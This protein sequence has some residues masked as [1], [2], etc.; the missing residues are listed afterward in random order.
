MDDE[1]AS[2]RPVVQPQLSDNDK[3]QHNDGQIYSELLYSEHNKPHQPQAGQL[4]R[5]QEPEFHHY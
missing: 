3:H 2:Q 4:L 5:F 1:R